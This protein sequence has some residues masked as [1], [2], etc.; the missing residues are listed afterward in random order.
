MSEITVKQEGFASDY[1]LH[2][3]ASKAYRDNYSAGKMKPKTVNVAACTLLKHHKVSI[4]V[5][6]LQSKIAE[7]AEEKFG[8]DAEWLLVRCVETENLDLLDIIDDLG[9]I[10]PLREWP[11]EWRRNLTGID[12]AEII[13]G[14]T[15]TIIK[16]FKWPDK[17]KNR[18]M[19]GKNVLVQ[20]FIDRKQVDVKPL[21]TNEP[22][23]E[24][25]RWIKET[26]GLGED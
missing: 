23:S 16:K 14:D 1:A 2:G 12:V 10:K 6:E 24:T 25:D 26:L 20:A 22:I 18:E 8:V 13:A 17:V 15:T 19:I 4:R 7:I 5:I 11:I 21:H 3:N 9:N